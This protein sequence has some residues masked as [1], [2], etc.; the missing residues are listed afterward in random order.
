[1]FPRPLDSSNSPLSNSVFLSGD[2]VHWELSVERVLHQ[3][4]RFEYTSLLG[5]LSN[6]IISREEA[7]CCVWMLNPS[8]SFLHLSRG[9]SSRLPPL[10]LH[11]AW[12]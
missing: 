7:D 8:G 1:M 4:E 12:P 5:L 6:V 9:I 11:L 2:G 3:F 10:L